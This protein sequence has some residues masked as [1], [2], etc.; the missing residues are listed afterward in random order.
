[1]ISY[2]TFITGRD[3]GG[4]RNPASWTL[5]GKDESGEYIELDAVSDPT[6]MVKADSY[7]CSYAVEGAAAYKEYK[8]VFVKDGD[9]QMDELVLYTNAQ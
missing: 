7:P 4:D 6:G 3:T 5:Y 1:M 2:Y 9:F 8:V